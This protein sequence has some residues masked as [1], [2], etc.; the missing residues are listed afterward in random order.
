MRSLKKFDDEFALTN[1][2]RTEGTEYLLEGARAA[3]TR[4]IVVQSYAGW[5][6]GRGGSRVKTEEDPLDPNPPEA[7]RHTLD[8]IRRLESTVAASSYIE[9]VVLRYGSFYGPVTQRPQAG[10]LSRRFVNANFL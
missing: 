5:P 3:G 10:R 6:S 7:M 9:G 4:K 2:L 8:S 1:R